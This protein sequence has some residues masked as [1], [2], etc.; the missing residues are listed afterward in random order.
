M[1]RMAALLLLPIGT[2][3]AQSELNSVL[4]GTYRVA[5]ETNCL[6]S[7]AGFEPPPSL[8]MK[9]FGGVLVEN[10]TAQLS[11]DGKGRATSLL[12]GTSFFPN[13]FVGPGGFPVNTFES[14][15]EWIYQVFPEQS[16]VMF[17]NCNARIPA[18]GGVIPGETVRVT[19]IR[20]R[21]SIGPRAETLLV[22][23]EPSVQHIAL[24]NG[25]ETD[26]ICD[27]TETG[28]LISTPQPN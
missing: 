15:C 5:G 26:R 2:A 18:G 11:F 19:G 6:T 1:L 12:A 7:D 9:G 24:G 23:V 14:Q 8:A 13:S 28:V 10:F 3:H 16:F 4:N 17:G 27:S 21:G 20:V 22:S 25:F